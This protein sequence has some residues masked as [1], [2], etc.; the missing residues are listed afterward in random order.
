MLNVIH[1]CIRIV[2]NVKRH[3]YLYVGHWYRL[4]SGTNFI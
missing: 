4:L 1:T 2:G 3:T